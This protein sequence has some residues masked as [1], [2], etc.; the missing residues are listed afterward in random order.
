MW[1]TDTD[2]LKCEVDKPDWFQSGLLNMIF[3]YIGIDRLSE[4]VLAACH[5]HSMVEVNKRKH[6]LLH[7]GPYWGSCVLNMTKKKWK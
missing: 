7:P 3:I 4:C 2:S 5:Y 6:R 1:C